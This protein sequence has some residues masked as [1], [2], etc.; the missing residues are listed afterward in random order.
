MFSDDQLINYSVPQGTVLG[1][2]L[3]IIYINGLLNQYFG[4]KV[5]CFADDTVYLVSY[6]CLHKLRHEANT[7][8]N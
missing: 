4:G 3:F 7:G 6:S 5:L 1:P 8:N 2:L